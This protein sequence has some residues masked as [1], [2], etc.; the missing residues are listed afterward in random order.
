[1]EKEA[2]IRLLDE[3]DAHEVDEVG[4][5][6]HFLRYKQQERRRQ[7]WKDIEHILAPLHKAVEE[8]GMSEDEINALIDEAIAEVRSQDND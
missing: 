2:V 4:Q 8:S 3:L 7:G 6:I 5:F 1:M